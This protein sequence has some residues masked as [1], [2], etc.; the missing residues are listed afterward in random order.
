[1]SRLQL[2]KRYAVVGL[3]ASGHSS[4][5]FLL[6]HAVSPLVCDTRKQPPG[7]AQLPEHLEVVCGELP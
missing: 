5:R 1:M 4:V 6:K 3:G 2:D 7:R